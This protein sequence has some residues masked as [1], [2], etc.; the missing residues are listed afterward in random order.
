MFLS[1]RNRMR[2]RRCVFLQGPA[3][4]KQLPGDLKGDGGF[5]RTRGQ[6]E[7]RAVF[8]VRNGLRGLGNGCGLIVAKRPAAAFFLERLCGKSI[9][10]GIGQ[11]EAGLPQFIRRGKGGDVA[12]LPVFHVYG[13]NFLPVGGI[14]EAQA[15]ARG[16]VFG[17]AHAFGVVFIPG[18]CLNDGKARAFV[19][20]QVVG[21]K[22]LVA[23]A[24]A[25]NAPSGDGKLAPD[26]AARHNAPPCLG[27]GRVDMF[28]T[29]F[30]FVHLRCTCHLLTKICFSP[31]FTH[32]QCLR[33]ALHIPPDGLAPRVDHS[34]TP[35]QPRA[36]G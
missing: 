16:V 6:G 30:R 20:Q 3:G 4:L 17:L 12:F 18:F 26:A 23:F 9:A 14:G 27:K 28:R 21:G 7:K 13:V 36:N 25:Q 34:R 22:G 32:W 2:G 8:A 33:Y 35:A 19:F 31:R 15:Q 5:T 1:A 24:L 10:P 29:G 11:R